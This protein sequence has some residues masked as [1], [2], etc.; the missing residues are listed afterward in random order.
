M[1]CAYIPTVV[2]IPLAT[3]LN[4]D[5]LVKPERKARK[6]LQRHG[7]NDDFEAVQRFAMGLKANAAAQRTAS[8]H[9]SAVEPYNPTAGITFRGSSLQAE[10][11]VRDSSVDRAATQPEPPPS[12][13]P[14][15]CK[16]LPV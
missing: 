11:G 14:E 7:L 10:P 2:G 13:A 6:H 9:L 16:C 3:H 12:Q 4:S 8:V 1:S 15:V 5:F